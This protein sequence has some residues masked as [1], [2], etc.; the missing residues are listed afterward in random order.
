MRFITIGLLSLAAAILLIM[1]HK[2]AYR[3]QNTAEEGRGERELSE[4][5][6]RSIILWAYFASLILLN[7]CF[8]FRFSEKIM[9]SYRP[10][11][12]TFYQKEFLRDG[13]YPDSL[14]P[15]LLSGKTVYMKNDPMDIDT[16]QGMG[17]EW[18]YSYYH[19][20]NSAAYVPFIDGNA[21]LDQTMNETMLSKEQI[22]EEFERL[23]MAND[24]YRYTFI[25]TPQW[26]ETGS[27]FYYY[28]YY[29]EVLPE[30]FAYINTEKDSAGED[31]GT[32]EELVLLWDSPMGEAEL[33]DIYL[34]TRRYYEEKVRFAGV[35]R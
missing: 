17:K 20:K 24:M 18:L 15:L 10:V 25:C 5:S 21:V 34:M 9:P 27:Y 19:A 30:F 3:N 35:D 13:L 12:Q 14:I 23:G 28:W 1:D 26:D 7:A 31:I 4:K 2:A 33:E 29:S 6:R 8:T 16:A 11:S 22:E 32:S